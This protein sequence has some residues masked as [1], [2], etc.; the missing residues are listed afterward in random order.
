MSEGDFLRMFCF[1][2]T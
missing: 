2:G 1:V